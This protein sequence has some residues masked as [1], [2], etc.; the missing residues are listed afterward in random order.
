MISSRGEIMELLKEYTATQH[1]WIYQFWMPGIEEWN[2]ERQV[3]YA[4]GIVLGKLREGD[5]ITRQVLKQ[6]VT[7]KALYSEISVNLERHIKKIEELEQ[8]DIMQQMEL[9][10]YKK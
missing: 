7:D 6:G 1:E 4:N 9:K 10:S 3:A 2:A 8:S 5:S